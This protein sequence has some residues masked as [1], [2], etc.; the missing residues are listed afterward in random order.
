[1]IAATL[2][3]LRRVMR[4]TRRKP[5]LKFYFDAAQ[6]I[7]VSLFGFLIVGAFLSMSYF[8]LFFHLV[9]IT[10]LLQVLVAERLTQEEP[11]PAPARA[12]VRVPPRGPLPVPVPNRA[13]S[14]PRPRPASRP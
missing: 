12:V 14:V 4:R 7:E 5:A 6:M 10:A 13:L 2:V 1:V 3:S 11:A 8:D 9:A